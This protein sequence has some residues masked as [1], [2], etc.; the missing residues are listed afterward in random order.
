VT[1]ELSQRPSGVKQELIF[2]PDGRDEKKLRLPYMVTE[3][4]NPDGSPRD[5][6]TISIQDSKIVV[7]RLPIRAATGENIIE[8]T[9]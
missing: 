8:F 9:R 6:I 7:Q 3:D 5:T 4:M 1:E 2:Y